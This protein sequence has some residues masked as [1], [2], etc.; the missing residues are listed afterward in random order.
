MCMF[1]SLSQSTDTG[2]YV[3]VCIPVSINRHRFLFSKSSS[4]NTEQ[5][6]EKDLSLLLLDGLSLVRLFPLAEYTVSLLGL[7]DPAGQQLLLLNELI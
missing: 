7:V 5:G 6:L 2:S 1:V 4:R 3:Y